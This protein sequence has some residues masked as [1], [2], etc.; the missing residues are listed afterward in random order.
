MF[1]QSRTVPAV[2]P[3]ALGSF[4]VVAVLGACAVAIDLY[5]I[6]RFWNTAPA[7]LFPILSVSI[8]LQLIYQWGRLLRYRAKVQD[9]CS[10]IS[11]DLAPVESIVRVAS[12]EMLELLFFS[13]GTILVALIVIGI[14]LSRMEIACK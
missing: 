13:Y 8:G 3:F 5:L 1:D 2:W 14:L 7:Y 10:S 11:V 12:H 4:I 9:L 6:Y